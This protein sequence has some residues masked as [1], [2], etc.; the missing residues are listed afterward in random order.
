VRTGTGAWLAAWDLDGFLAWRRGMGTSRRRLA[1][2]EPPAATA[3]FAEATRAVAE[4]PAS[5]FEHRDEIVFGWA[6][7]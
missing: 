1:S 5:A 3:A 6:T 2:L 7:A 4:L